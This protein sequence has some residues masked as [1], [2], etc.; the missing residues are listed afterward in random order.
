MRHGCDWACPGM[1]EAMKNT[2]KLLSA[3][4]VPDY[5]LTRYLPTED[6]V[7][8]WRDY[9]EAYRE[10]NENPFLNDPGLLDFSSIN[11]YNNHYS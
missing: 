6:P 8:R 2:I 3:P 7:G 10:I 4:D 5:L 1:P 11:I 9:N